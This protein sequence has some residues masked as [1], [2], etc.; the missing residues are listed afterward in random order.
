MRIFFDLKPDLK[1][2]VFLAGVGRSGT[3]WM[4]DVINARNDYRMM[5]EPFHPYKVPL[6]REFRYRQYLG[7]DDTNSHYVEAARTILSGKIRNPWIDKHNRRF[8][9]TK[10][11]VKDIRANLMLKWLH[12]KFP[13]LKI[14]VLMRH[15]CAVANSKLKLGWATHLN[16]FLNQADLMEAHLAPFKELLESAETDFEKHILLWCVENYVPLRQF[17]RGEVYFA[18]YERLCAQPEEEFGKVFAFLGLDLPIECRRA[19]GRPSALARSA[20]AVRTGANLIDSWRVDISGAQ[21][22]RAQELLS[23][24]GLSRIY[25][26]DSMPLMDPNRMGFQAGVPE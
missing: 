10:R 16:E 1:S 2:S 22:A 11:L 14:V 5:F 12:S 3:T 25:G 23:A 4:A 17:A 26:E 18:S 9:V 7:P 13:E 19:F 21:T 15:P 8:M 24:F 6:C 20:S